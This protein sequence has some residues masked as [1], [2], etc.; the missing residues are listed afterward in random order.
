MTMC[1]WAQSFD[2]SAWNKQQKEA[3]VIALIPKPT[4]L[5][6]GSGFIDANTAVAYLED[7]SLKGEAYKL[8]IDSTG[9]TITTGTAIGKIRAQQTL[10]QLE[11]LGGSGK[12]PCVTISDKPRFS[13]RGLM[14]DV[15]R[16]FFDKEAVMQLL[17]VMGL[18]HFSVLHMHL[19]DD[20]GWRVEIP[21]YPLLTEVGAVRKRSFTV[22]SSPTTFYDD[23]EY[24]RGMYYTLDDLRELVAYAAE[25]GI[26]IIPEYDLPGH[27]VAAVASYPKLLASTATPYEG[28][29]TFEVR[30]NGGISKDV[31][32]VGKEEV[33]DF[34]KCVLG[35]LAEVFPSEYIHLGGDE[36]PTNAWQNCT[37]VQELMKREGL[38]NLS[39][40]QPWLLEKLGTWL[41]EEYGKT[42]ICWDELL[43]HWPSTN[44]VKP[45]IMAWNNISYTQ[46]AADWGFKSICVPYQTLYLDFMQALPA[47][48][49]FDEP[50]YGGWT[51]TNVNT[52][53]EVYDIN[54][55]SATNKANLVMGPQG[56][57]W[58]ET[59][60]S[61]EEMQHCFFP[62]A[63]AL[64]EVGWKAQSSRNWNDFLSRM[65]FH[66]RV[67]DTLGISY[68]K[69]YFIQPTTTL[70]DERQR[71]LAATIPGEAGYVSQADY[72]ALKNATTEHLETA[73]TAYKEAN[74]VQPTEGQYYEIR[75][76]STYYK[77]H[78]NGSTLYKLDSDSKIHYTQQLN[79]E[80]LW[81]F[82]AAS[83]GKF[84][85]KNAID[86]IL[87]GS[88][89][90]LQT[91]K[92][93]NEK[94]D[95][96]P[97]VI[98]IVYSLASTK[99]VYF[100]N[101]NG[102]VSQTT[103]TD[104]NLKI[105]YPGTWRLIRVVDFTAYLAKLLPNVQKAGEDVVSFGE[106][107]V[108]RGEVTQHEYD[109]YLQTYKTGTV[110][111]ELRNLITGIDSLSP[112]LPTREGE[113]YNLSGQRITAP[114]K[115]E[116][117]IQNSKNVI[118]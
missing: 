38:E 74:I 40:V 85:I 32:N 19:T 26:E 68:A 54:P 115:G 56:N 20:Q 8:S 30:V 11:L 6:R 102:T 103:Y 35:H 84:K 24:G 62:R 104:D 25:R 76:A 23:T 58:T 78:Y 57:L 111:Q 86:K 46:K 100:A 116:I 59:C 2:T 82:T 60:T 29:T 95:Y 77:A 65:Q 4:S 89:L 16:H 63:L 81:T 105:G 15:A 44:K 55:T 9:I 88:G 21:E 71:L 90:L 1:L 22:P 47:D 3:Q 36:C 53:P 42:V 14:L 117:Y 51:E 33:M 61:V 75:S 83:G 93:A 97:G 50:Y 99:K 67:L 34:M 112:T 106:Q 101:Q 79:P 28:G 18:Y 91:A 64:A 10:R 94:T 110:P 12:V 118:F 48:C 7:T 107:L 73:I 27:N 96:E 72:D 41:Q 114:K 31:L 66:A 70:E 45:V 69:H 98:N 49:Y 92:V 13:Y 43:S 80:E 87:F 52:L 37:A 109:L 108:E 17:D 113:I 39:A 5:V